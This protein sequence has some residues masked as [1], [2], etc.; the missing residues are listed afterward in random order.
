METSNCRPFKIMPLKS[1]HL[2]FTFASLLIF[3]FTEVLLSFTAVQ[4]VPVGADVAAAAPGAEAVPD[5]GAATTTAAP[6]PAPT[7][8]PGQGP[9]PSPSHQ[10][11]F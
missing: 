10:K 5:P 8:D 7:P 1:P 11:R 9:G 6:G 2:I 4:S 3:Y